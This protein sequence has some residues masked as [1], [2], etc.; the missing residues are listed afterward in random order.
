VLLDKDELDAVKLEVH[1]HHRHRGSS[2]TPIAIDRIYWDEPYY[3]APSR[4]D[5]SRRLL[6]HQAAMKK[7]ARL[8]WASLV[9]H[10]RERPCAPRAS[11]TA[12]SCSP[13]LAPMTRSLERR[14][15]GK[16]LAQARSRHAGDR[17]EDHRPAGQAK[18]DPSISRTA[19]RTRCA[20]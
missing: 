20:T 9:L 5:R 16:S 17:R 8:R 12:A 4:Q 6:G 19:T 7:Q 10:Q 3:L 2:S 18:F 11:A 14:I 1:T 15:L 13:T